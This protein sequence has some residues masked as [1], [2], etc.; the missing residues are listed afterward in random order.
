VACT[1]SWIDAV[2]VL[3]ALFDLPVALRTTAPKFTP[4][5]SFPVGVVHF[6]LFVEVAVGSGFAYAS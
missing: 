1:S 5:G 4:T 2:D 6:S 3:E